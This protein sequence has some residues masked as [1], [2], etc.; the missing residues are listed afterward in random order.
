MHYINQFFA[1]EGGEDRADVP[2]SISKGTLGPGKRLQ[3]M[4]GKST[5]IVATVYCGDNYF[6]SHRDEALKKILEFAKEYNIDMLVAGP[7]FAAGRYGFACVEVCH[8]VSTTLDLYCVTGMHNDNPGVEGYKQYKDKKVFLLPTADSVGGM[9]D[10][11]SRIAQF[12]L[13]LAAGSAIG[14]ATEEG[15]VPRGFRLVKVVNQM[16]S[17]RA[18]NMLLNKLAGK[19]F[20]TE[21]PIE[22][23][24]V[25][26]VTP[27]IKNIKNAYLALVTTSG[28]VPVGNPAGIK[29]SRN[30][31]WSKYS[32]ENINS[33]TDSKWE[34]VHC[35]YDTTYMQ[36]N[37][38][39]GVPVD[40]CKKLL[41][42]GTFAKLYPYFYMTTGVVAITFEMQRIGKEIAEDMKAQGIDAALLVST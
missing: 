18:I 41:K 30:T 17:E 2:F 34:V 26:P 22:K 29:A 31:K 25:I 13:K 24:E 21:F 7:A 20:V 42:E 14:P 32:I 12:I 9:E 27:P 19:P 23:E 11:L 16:G 37:P 38:N 6:S 15:Y 39:F 28:V 4:L 36:K 40:I 5:E 1:G 35:G 10:A 3:A 33:M 8:A